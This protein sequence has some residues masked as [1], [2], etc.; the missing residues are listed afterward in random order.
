[1]KKEVNDFYN[2]LR[3]MLKD[4]EPND[5][6]KYLKKLEEH[7]EVT[8]ITQNVDDF[9]ERAG[10]TNIIHLHGELTKVRKEQ[11][12]FYE[13]LGDTVM[14]ENI[15]Y[16]PLDIEKRPDYRP[17]IVFFGDIVPLIP[18]AMKAVEE[19]DIFVVAGTSL[20]V[21]PAASLIE[22]VGRDVPAYIIDPQKVKISRID[23]SIYVPDFTHIKEKASEGMKQLY[24]ILTNE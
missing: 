8:I 23:K 10:S 11:D 2:L 3:G 21:Y 9:H 5:A 6:H 18:K 17:A 20:E 1:M 19:A 14:W 22:C 13:K 15:G 24:E 4:Y 7:Y 16:E 12:V